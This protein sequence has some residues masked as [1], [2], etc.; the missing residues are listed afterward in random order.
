MPEFQTR[1][2]GIRTGQ[3]SRLSELRCRNIERPNSEW[4]PPDIGCD[5]A[6]E[7]AE[8]VLEGVAGTKARDRRVASAGHPDR[9]VTGLIG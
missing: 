9:N 1:K 5:I 8:F 3:V 4:P 2:S 7:Q 6:L